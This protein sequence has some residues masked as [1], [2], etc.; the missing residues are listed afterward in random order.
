MRTLAAGRQP[1]FGFAVLFRLSADQPHERLFLGRVPI[2]AQEG[3][4]FDV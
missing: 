2:P 1:S 4:E 3:G